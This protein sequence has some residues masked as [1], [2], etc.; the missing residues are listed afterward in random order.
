MFSRKLLMSFD[1]P[2]AKPIVSE[3]L[4]QGK[5]IDGDVAGAL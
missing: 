2:T 4:D 1:P 3:P 5:V